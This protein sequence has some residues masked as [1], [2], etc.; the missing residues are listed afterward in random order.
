MAEYLSADIA[1]CRGF[2]DGPEGWLPECYD[3]LRRTAPWAG[4]PGG[5]TYMQPPQIVTFVC[6]YYIEPRRKERP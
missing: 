1:R 3:C 4:I 2:G 5:G 6:D